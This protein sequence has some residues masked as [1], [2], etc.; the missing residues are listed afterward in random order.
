MD[1]AVVNHAARRDSNI[2]VIVS[3]ESS[4]RQQRGSSEVEKLEHYQIVK[5]LSSCHWVW[6]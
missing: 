2:E 1:E 3:C 6:S 4:R 5:R